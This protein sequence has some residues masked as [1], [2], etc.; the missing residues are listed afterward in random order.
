MFEWGIPVTVA[1]FVVTV[2]AFVIV[3]AVSVWLKNVAVVDFYWATGFVVIAGLN[4][5][6]TPVLDAADNAIVIT[7]SIWAARLVFYTGGRFFGDAHEDPRYAAFRAEAGPGWWWMS[8]FK[9]FLLQALLLFVFAAPIHANFLADRD[10]VIQGLLVLGVAVFLVGFVI[11]TFADLQLAVFRAAPGNRGR[12]LA[13][14][15][16]KYSRHPNYFGELLVWVGITLIAFSGGAPWWAAIGPLALLGALWFVSIPLTE[17][18][19]ARTRPAYA[20]YQRRV[21]PLVPMPPKPTDPAR[22]PAE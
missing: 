12:V 10:G 11:E 21:S 3:W 2:T 5:A 16:W 7:V 17:A 20:E 4:A 14:R 13:A 6:A 8:L 19:L 18:H 15:L 9:V 1:T 22:Q